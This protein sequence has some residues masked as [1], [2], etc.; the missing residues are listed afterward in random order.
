[1]SSITERKKVSLTAYQPES[2]YIGKVVSPS[3]EYNGGVRTD[4]VIGTT[5]TAVNIQS[6]DMIRV[7]VDT[8]KPV[9]TNDMLIEAESLGKHIFLEFENA[10]IKVYLSKRNGNATIEDSITASGMN[11]VDAKF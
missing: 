4:K 5:V 8:V 6:F 7:K 3:Y 9:I 1:M 10:E 11:V 2:V